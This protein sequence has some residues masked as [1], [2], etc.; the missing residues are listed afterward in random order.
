M[1]GARMIHMPLRAHETAWRVVRL[2]A[3]CNQ[4]LGNKAERRASLGT[5]G[6]QKFSSLERL[7]KARA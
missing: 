5:K 3:P 2:R 1:Q 6:E 4:A 7:D